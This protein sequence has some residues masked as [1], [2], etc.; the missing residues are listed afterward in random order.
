MIYVIGLTGGISTGKTNISAALKEIGAY[1]ADADEISHA[2]TAKNGAALPAIRKAFGD[3][4]FD[5]DTLNRRA[6][7]SIIFSDEQSRETLN[8]IL[9]PMIFERIKEDIRHAEQ[10]G[11]P[12]VILD[13]PLLYETGYDKICHEIWVSYVPQKEQLKRL[14]E[15]DGITQ[16]QA[17]QKI[18]SQMPAI[19]KKR[20][21]DRVINTSGTL[22]ESAAIAQKMYRET[23]EKI[24]Q[25][26]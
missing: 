1:V 22:E 9:H 11:F 7:G 19:E 24:K 3:K 10:K 13:V 26:S 17:L 6:L 5:G 16:K 18:R 20:R 23:L 15:R 2:L 25:L 21:A 12:A 8:N 14:C 4:V